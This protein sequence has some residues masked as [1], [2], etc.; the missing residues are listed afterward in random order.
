MTDKTD[1]RRPPR[2]GRGGNGNRGGNG[3]SRDGGGAR[4]SRTGGFGGGRDR[5]AR[6]DRPAGGGFGARGDRSFGEKRPF[7]EKRGF[8]DRRPEGGPGRPDRGPRPFHGERSDRPRF[9]QTHPGQDRPGQDRPG[10]ERPRQDRP[11][12]DRPRQDRPDGERRF[13][14]GRGFGEKR[15]F[16]EKRGFGKRD[17]APRRDAGH[18][19]DARPAFSGRPRPESARGSYSERFSD[20]PAGRQERDRPDRN[21]PRPQTERVERPDGRERLAKV[22][23]RAGVASRRDA[24][25]IIIAG[26]VSVNGQ[27]IHSPAINVGPA[28]HILIDGKPMPARERTRL[29]LYN[30]PAGLVTT[31]FD[32]EGRPTVFQHL[33]GDLPHVISVG[34]LDINTEGLLLLTNDGGLARVLSHPET[35]WLRRYR[36]RAYGQITPDALLALENGVTID[37]I[38]YGPVQASIQRQQGHNVWLMLGLRE[39]KNREVKR[40][41][42]HLG[43]RVNRLIR[44]SF[45]PFQLGDIPE[46]AAD[47]VRLAVLKSQLGD[48]LARRAGADF[49]SPAHE[50]DPGEGRPASL[51][52]PRIPHRLPEEEAVDA[53]FDEGV[54]EE[55]REAL[56]GKPWKDTSPFDHDDGWFEPGGRKAAMRAAASDAYARSAPVAPPAPRG[57]PDP[58]RPSPDDPAPQKAVGSRVG[59]KRSTWRDAETEAARAG[60]GSRKPRRG[61]DPLAARAESGQRAHVRAG[62]VAS[63]G[64]RRVLVEKVVREKPEAPVRG[65][66]SFRGGGKPFGGKPGF[67]ARDGGFGDRPPRG[68]RAPGRDRFSGGRQDF[69]ARQE[70]GARKNVGENRS[71]DRQGFG[72][73]AFAGKP[74]AGKPGGKSFGGKSFGNKPSGAR[75]ASGR[76]FGKPGGKP[77]GGKPGDGKS[78]GGRGPGR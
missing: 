21:R 3:G 73:R 10:Q 55:F 67:A 26:R 50:R 23:A 72:D 7:G 5:D 38:H 58:W 64:G 22:M 61:D 14:G 15:P 69:G 48:D 52:P 40:I 63:P 2:Q 9:G 71:G 46:G 75:P 43:L 18:Y 24:E 25:I 32:P 77:F 66:R 78:G 68:D 56:K 76:P 29:W 37:G 19:G 59:L 54:E 17:G 70:F 11:F 30:K 41:L 39:G 74:F 44:I 57:T 51:L 33:P 28:D 31:Q 1:N 49:E 53:A 60:T 35:G 8:G 13:S 12:H 16:G 20:R 27:V 62:A 45:G 34:R 47:E 36:V 4:G 42:E 65:E 6:G